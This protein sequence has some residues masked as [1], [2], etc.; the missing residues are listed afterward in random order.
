MPKGPGWSKIPPTRLSG[1]V[2]LMFFGDGLEFI[3]LYKKGEG[4][5]GRSLG[6]YGDR[7]YKI[8]PSPLSER[9]EVIDGFPPARQ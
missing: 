3:D 4:S 5:P 7:P 9:G 6:W 8:P 2:I 1:D